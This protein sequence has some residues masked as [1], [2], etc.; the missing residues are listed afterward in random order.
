M[1][2]TFNDGQEL[3]IQQVAEQTDGALLIK[4]ISA[5]EE[6]KTLFS[7]AVATKR[8]SVSERDADTVTYENYTK[9]DAIVKYTAGILGVMMY[10]EGEDPDSRIAALEAR[11]KEAEEKNADLQT[12]VGKAE[13][14]NEMLKGC[15]LEMSETVYQ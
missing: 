11:L 12:R 9:L 1:K 6:L 4:T 14:E 15:I 3:Q 5:E 8:M 13:E 10:Q 7:D 2:I